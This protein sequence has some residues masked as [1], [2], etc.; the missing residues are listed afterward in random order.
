MDL[1]VLLLPIEG[2]PILP[3]TSRRSP[4]DHPKGVEV[5]LVEHL[6]AV[7]YRR[8]GQR[9]VVT[10]LAVGDNS[11]HV[12][13]VV[14]EL[15]SLL[16]EAAGADR[17]QQL[18]HQ[19]L[20]ADRRFTTAGGTCEVAPVEGRG[21]A[22]GVADR[23]GLVGVEPGGRGHQHGTMLGAADVPPAPAYGA[24]HGVGE[25]LAHDLVRGAA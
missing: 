25:V 22:V 7:G 20:Q 12:P 16:V 11:P 10:E 23:K 4:R 18:V 13:Q 6:G 8:G 3:P 14:G 19:G 9:T 15:V 5:R 17:G 2:E 21:G 1:V 24:H